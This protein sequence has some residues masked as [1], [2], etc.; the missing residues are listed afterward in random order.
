VLVGIARA[1]AIIAALHRE[2]RAESSNFGPASMRSIAMHRREC[3]G[4]QLNM[5]SML[6]MAFQ[7]L[8]FFILTFQPPPVEKALIE[9]MPPLK[10]A[11][12]QHTESNEKPGKT[13]LPE[14]A[15]PKLASIDALLIRVSSAA[16]GIDSIAVGDTPLDNSGQLRVRLHEIFSNPQ[17]PIDRIVVETSGTLRYGELMAVVDICA[18]LHLPNGKPLE[19]LSFVEADKYN[20]SAK[21]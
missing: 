6:D 21:R 20:T 11:V 16:G 10:T 15:M 3:D 7:L 19:R 5:A 9:H 1:A 13:P 14:P 8:T 12:N 4:V 2:S 18:A 17:N